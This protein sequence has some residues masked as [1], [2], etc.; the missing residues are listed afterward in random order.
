MSSF[1]KFKERLP[2]NQNFYSSLMGKT[3]TNKNYDHALKVWN[4]IEMKAMKDFYNL[5]LECD[6]LLLFVL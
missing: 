3:I 2:S 6:V 5:Y 1:K 4:A